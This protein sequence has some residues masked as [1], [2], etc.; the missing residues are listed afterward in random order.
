MLYGVQL[1]VHTDHKNMSH[2]LGKFT[3]QRVLR[4]RLF[5][6]QYGCEFAYIPGPQNVVADA[7]SRV[8]RSLEEE[9]SASKPK[10][11]FADAFSIELDN[12]EMSDCFLNYPVFNKEDPQE[13]PLDYQT[14]QHYQQNDERL[15]AA[16]QQLPNKFP[17][18][19]ITNGVELIVYQKEPDVPW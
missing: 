15:Q 17:R 5:L 18:I 12:I 14:I 8:P 3:M 6:E 10:T 7:L 16:S 4:W 2:Q 11:G 19:Q 13:Y 1:I 9:S